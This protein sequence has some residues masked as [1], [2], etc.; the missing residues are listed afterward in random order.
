MAPIPPRSVVKLLLL[1]LLAIG[2]VLGISAQCAA[3]AAPSTM[4]AA[5]DL[6][7]AGM[8]AQPHRRLKADTAFCGLCA[9][10]PDTAAAILAEMLFA[11]T[12]PA[13]S[14]LAKLAGVSHGPAPPPP[15]IA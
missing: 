10:I 5:S 9:A 1:A 11:K 4:A 15:R 13:A 7:C 2:L 6:H 3:T 14:I 12:H 8:P